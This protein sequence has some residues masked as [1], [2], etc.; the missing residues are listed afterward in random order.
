M[1]INSQLGAYLYKIAADECPSKSAEWTKW[2]E[3]NRAKLIEYTWGRNAR[4]ELVEFLLDENHDLIGRIVHPASTLQPKELMYF[5]YILACEA[6]H[7]EQIINDF[8][9]GDRY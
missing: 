1:G 4:I 5:A 8:E 9:L 2:D 3:E 6:D 7:L